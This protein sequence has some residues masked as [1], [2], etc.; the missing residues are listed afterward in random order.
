MSES[1]APESRAPEEEGAEKE[2]QE[3]KSPESFRMTF[4]AHLEELRKRLLICIVALLAGM[5]VSYFFRDELFAF[6]LHPLFMAREA[7]ATEFD[8]TVGQP[9]DE[10][11]PV[12][13]ADLARRSLTLSKEALDAPEA[14]D[15]ARL[16]AQAAS[17]AQTAR[18]H[19]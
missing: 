12:K 19:R 1:E 17:F 13:A 18:M 8:D 10:D 14:R 15:A 2:N 6:I 5:A 9:G 3:T 16:A 7:V 4:S 11:G